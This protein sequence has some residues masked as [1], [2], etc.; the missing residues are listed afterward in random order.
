MTPRRTTLVALAA[1]SLAVLAPAAPAPV[2]P[3]AG[4]DCTVKV[5]GSTVTAHCHNPNS[6]TDRVRLHVECA[7]WWDVDTDGA[8]ADVTPARAVD[9]DGRCWKEVASAWVSHRPV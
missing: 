1:A 3:E 4:A 7:R 5:A 6:R 2:P 8:P 9:L